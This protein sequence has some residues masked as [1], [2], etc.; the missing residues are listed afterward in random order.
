MANGECDY[1]GFADDLETGCRN[2]VW[3]YK[4]VCRLT[5]AGIRHMLPD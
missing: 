1:D 2:A 3:Y 4:S 5:K